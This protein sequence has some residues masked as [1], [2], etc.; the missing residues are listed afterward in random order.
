V[1]LATGKKV[2]TATENWASGKFGNGDEE[3]RK[4]G[5]KN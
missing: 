4:K 2:K 5:N 3:G 1:V